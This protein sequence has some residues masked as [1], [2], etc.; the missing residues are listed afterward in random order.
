[1]DE[2][3]DGYRRGV[4]LGLTV[5]EIFLLLLFL[6]LI[7]ALAWSRAKETELTETQD[8][9]EVAEDRLEEWRGPMEEFKTP[10]EIRTLRQRKE[11]LQ[12][13][14]ERAERETE[15][16]RDALQEQGAGDATKRLTE[17]LRELD[18]Q[19]AEAEQRLRLLQ[20]GHNPPCWYRE[21]SDGKGGTREKPYYT[22]NVAVLDQHFVVL[23][24][25]T[26]PGGAANDSKRPY[27]VEAADLRLGTI[28]YGTPL[29]N[30]ALRK[31][32]EPVSQA[33]KNAQVRSYPCVFW[34]RVWDKLSHSA[35]AKDRWKQAHDDILEGMF[36]AYTVK[37]EPWPGP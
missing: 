32:L 18:A 34:V 1:M 15:M 11:Q 19:K 5:A 12:R 3:A 24:T 25:Q 6:I 4:V 37:D 14:K 35:G 30:A 22:F 26:P 20:K 28:P 13:E 7:A 27:A 16:L 10:E 33:G 2:R 17:K 21:V 36:G 29:D 23:R 8:R 31:H 9:L